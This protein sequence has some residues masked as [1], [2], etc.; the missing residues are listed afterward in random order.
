MMKNICGINLCRPFRTLDVFLCYPG[1]ALLDLG[2]NITAF[3]A[4]VEKIVQHIPLRE[5]ILSILK[6]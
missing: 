1:L 5:K 6:P 3:Q 4:S 2:C